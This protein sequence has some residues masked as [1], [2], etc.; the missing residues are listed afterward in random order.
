MDQYLEF[1]KSVIRT[2]KNNNE[3]NNF[4]SKYPDLLKTV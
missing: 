3:I 4:K 1:V 2:D